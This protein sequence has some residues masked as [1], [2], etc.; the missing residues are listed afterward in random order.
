MFNFPSQES[1]LKEWTSR[2]RKAA[3]I[4]IHPSDTL[5]IKHFEEKFVCRYEQAYDANFERQSVQKSKLCLT[6][7]AVPTL[8]LD[9]TSFSDAGR[10]ETAKQKKRGS[11]GLANLQKARMR[12]MLRKERMKNLLRRRTSQ[13]NESNDKNV[14][15]DPEKDFFLGNRELTEAE[16]LIIPL[17]I[18]S[19]LKRLHDGSNL[20][21]NAVPVKD[22][23]SFPTLNII[24]HIEGISDTNNPLHWTTGETF[25]FMKYISPIKSIPVNFRSE[26]I[27]GEALLNLTKSDLI[28]HFH[29]D[30]LTSDGLIRIFAQ[31]RREVIRRFVNI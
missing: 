31:L 18:P 19:L 22:N 7:D 3:D 2:I 12:K 13:K 21:K 25:Q 8:H 4:K 16:K 30:Q 1:K 17:R 29:L 28:D 20:C 9:F 24:R 15:Y 5:C 26:E 11:S 10:L 6:K 23:P 27:D 14:A